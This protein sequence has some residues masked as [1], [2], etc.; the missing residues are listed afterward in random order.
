LTA[1]NTHDLPSFR[2][3]M[4]GA[5]L[6]VKRAI[7]VDPGETDGARSLAQAALRQTLGDFA[8]S[9]AVDSFAAAAG[10]LAATP[11]RIVSVG[12]EDMLDVVDQVN[13]PGTVDQHPNWRRKL[14]VPLEEWTSLPSFNA[15]CAAF[16]YTGRS[17]KR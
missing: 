7:D 11:S 16:D 5:D 8:G 17:R 9:N 14:P 13:I 6:A 12:I 10:F 1:F 2:G 3:W 15:V 4:S